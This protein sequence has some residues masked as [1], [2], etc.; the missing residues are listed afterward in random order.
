MQRGRMSTNAEPGGIDLVDFTPDWDFTVGGAK[1]I[2]T[3]RTTNDDIWDQ[4]LFVMFDQE[5]VGSPRGLC[6]PVCVGRG[7]CVGGWWNQGVVRTPVCPFVLQ[8]L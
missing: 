2:L 1:M 6:V 8:F 5:Q 3:F 7:G 4:N